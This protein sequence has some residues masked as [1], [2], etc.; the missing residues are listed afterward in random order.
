MKEYLLFYLLLSTLVQLNLFD[1][2]EE[3]KDK[4]KKIKINILHAYST[5]FS[6]K[7]DYFYSNLG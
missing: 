2:T 4:L 7:K 3:Y 1:I 5:N 6:I